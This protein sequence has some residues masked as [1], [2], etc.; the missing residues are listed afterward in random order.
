MQRITALPLLLQAIYIAI[1]RLMPCLDGSNAICDSRCQS[2]RLPL[3]RNVTVVSGE[4]VLSSLY[5]ILLLGLNVSAEVDRTII[6]QTITV[7]R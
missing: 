1:S 5:Y 6:K 2:Y 3:V 4:L 7:L